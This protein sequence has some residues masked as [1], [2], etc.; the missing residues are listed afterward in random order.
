MAKRGEMI[1]TCAGLFLGA[2]GYQMGWKGPEFFGLLLAAIG[3]GMLLARPE[4]SL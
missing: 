3:L 1:L 2:L 4:S